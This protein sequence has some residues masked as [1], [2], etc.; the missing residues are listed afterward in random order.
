MRYEVRGTPIGINGGIRPGRSA[1]VGYVS[2][3]QRL[4]GQQRRQLHGSDLHAW[5]RC[6]IIAGPMRRLLDV[7]FGPPLHS[8]VIAGDV[9]ETE[10]EMV[11]PYMMAVGSDGCGKGA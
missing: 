5:I 4:P 7:D 3:V 2:R 1:G 8:L 6:V 9:H 10:R 11:E